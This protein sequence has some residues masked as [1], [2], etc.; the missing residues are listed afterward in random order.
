MKVNYGLTTQ[1]PFANS[2]PVATTSQMDRRH[3]NL[4]ASTLDDDA[5][6]NFANIATQHG[7]RTNNNN[8]VNEST[9]SRAAADDDV[10]EHFSR[11]QLHIGNVAASNANEWLNANEALN[12]DDQ[13]SNQDDTDINGLNANESA[14]D[15]SGSS[16]LGR[17]KSSFSMQ[18]D[19]TRKVGGLFGADVMS[20]K[21]SRSSMGGLNFGS[22]LQGHKSL[23]PSPSDNMLNAS[24]T[25]LNSLH[26]RPTSMYGSTSALSDSRLLRGTHSP[27]YNGRTMFGG[28]SAYSRRASSSQRHLR[29]PTQI[30]PSSSLSA[31]STQSLAAASV[32]SDQAVSVGGAQSLALSNTAKRI[33]ELM[34]QFTTPLSDVKKM[35]NATPIP[36]LVANRKRFGESDILLNRS[37]RLNTPA[38]PYSRSGD[39]T[40]RR[41]NTSSMM[42]TEL[43]VPTMSSLLHMKKIM[44]NNTERVNKTCW[45]IMKVSLIIRHFQLHVFFFFLC[46]PVRF[47]T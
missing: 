25:S 47:A 22:H 42:S 4:C 45:S 7:K 19:Q 2:T 27:F 17:R 31:T 32:S 6:Y 16:V 13:A 26:R 14:S 30:R 24:T 9:N 5:P 46:L 39:V 33:L 8:N 36:A 43:Q 10:T 12:D 20:H 21:L 34:N 29:V 23:F 1:I 3:R 37:V 18:R 44:Q 35:S 38:T 15:E 28:A 41:T 40:S 11:R